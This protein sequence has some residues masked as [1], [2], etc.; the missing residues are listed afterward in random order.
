M[1]LQEWVRG[2]RVR[3][4]ARWRGARTLL[5]YSGTS[6]PSFQWGLCTTC[7]APP[8]G[9]GLADRHSSSSV[10]SSGAV[11]SS[12]GAR[13]IAPWPGGQRVRGGL[14]VDI[15]SCRTVAK[16]RRCSGAERRRAA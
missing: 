7:P 2:R 13:R 4:P 6:S 5:A 3:H 12:R 15:R 11:G 9:C 1:L 16:V 10:Y 8:Q 14:G